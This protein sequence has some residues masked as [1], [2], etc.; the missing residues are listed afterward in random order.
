MIPGVMDPTPTLA[1]GI[2]VWNDIGPEPELGRYGDIIL[3]DAQT[4]AETALGQGRDEGEVR[5]QPPV[6]ELDGGDHHSEDRPVRRRTPNSKYPSDVYV[7]SS[8]RT[9]SRTMG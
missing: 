9:R 4:P 7:L 6:D 1:E 3:D 5:A 8:A 2:P